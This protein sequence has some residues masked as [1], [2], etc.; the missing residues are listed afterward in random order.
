ML[1]LL[2]DGF[3]VVFSVS[4]FPLIVMAVA[5]GIV[6]GSLPGLTATMG[7]A[8]LL[9]FTFG[10]EPITGIATMMGVFVVVCPEV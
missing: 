4:I 7:V 2:L 3:R 6:I 1:A 9:P 5:G 10:M 8:V